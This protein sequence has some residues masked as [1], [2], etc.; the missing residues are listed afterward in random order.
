MSPGRCSAV[1]WRRPSPT[2]L[3]VAAQPSARRKHREGWSPSRTIT[4]SA[5]SVAGWTPT[6]QMAERSAPVRSR[7]RPRRMRRGC[8]GCGTGVFGQGWRE[9]ESV[10]RPPR[11][12]GRRCRSLANKFRCVMR[13][14]ALARK[15]ARNLGRLRPW[16]RRHG[17]GPRRWPAGHLAARVSASAFLPAGPVAST[18]DAGL[19]R[20]E[21]ILRLGR[22]EASS[23][24]PGHPSRSAPRS[25]PAIVPER[26]P[27]DRPWPD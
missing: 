17:A 19:V 4:S 23:G 1:I 13:R 21:T 7:L 3:E 26:S 5:W 8:W 14:G 9:L 22:E 16:L 20:W 18:K 27:F 6:R 15:R 24:C 10:S 12:D 25:R 2:S 11:Q